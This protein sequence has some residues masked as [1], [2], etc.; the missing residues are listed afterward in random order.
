MGDEFY[1]GFIETDEKKAIEKFK[2]RNDF[3]TYEQCKSLNG[4]AGVLDEDTC[5]GDFDN[6]EEAEI[7]LQMI[8][9]EQL[10]CRVVKT[11]R[12][13]HVLF[14]NKERRVDSCSTK[15]PTASTLTVDYKVGHKAS[16]EALKVNGVEREVVYDAGEYEEVPIHF[17]PVKRKVGFAN[18]GDSDGRN[19][20]LFEYILTLQDA[21]FVKDEIREIERV[22]NKYVL[23]DPLSEKELEIILR[24]ESFLK[25]SFSKSGK[26]QH[27]LL[28]DYLI[29]EKHIISVNEQLH[30]Y[31]NG[32][33]TNRI[34]L[35]NRAMIE[36]LPNISNNQRRETLTYMAA[37][38][39][40][41]ELSAINKIPVLNGLFNIENNALEEFTPNYIAKNKIPVAYNPAAYDE[42]IDKFLNDISCNDSNIRAIIEEMIGCCLYRSNS[43][44]TMFILTG[45]GSNGKS[46]LLR[47]LLNLLGNENT[48]SVD[49]KELDRTFKTAELFGKLANIGDDISN[50][51][52]RNSS[53]IKKLSSG[54]RNNAEKKG[55]DPFEFNNYATMIFSCNTM[56]K[57]NDNTNGL[58]R[59]LLFIPLN[60]VFKKSVDFENNILQADRL[61]YLLKLGIEGLQ[62]YLRSGEF[63]AS[64]MAESTKEDYIIANDPVK[65]FL[66]DFEH[67]TFLNEC[68]KE[69]FMRFRSWCSNNGHTYDYDVRKF[70][71]EVN[72]ITGFKS[73]RIRPPKGSIWHGKE[74]KINI[75]VLNNNENAEQTGRTGRRK[76]T[77]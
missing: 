1:K 73:E 70:T 20:A 24:D 15:V 16:Y 30:I 58:A 66:H 71:K 22:V 45:E 42:E 52:I 27:N 26:F 29:R 4:F 64:N 38:A 75:F 14:K 36:Q 21:G 8:K 12:G 44:Q 57:V 39:K 65:G 74:E 48:C 3:K 72:A 2:N 32:I 5:L 68:T 9:G 54:E 63:T 28:G 6:P 77:G 31:E 7:A 41:T 59:R 76:R 25:C 19:S 23:K 37:V 34:K 67:K 55:Q 18:M 53:L 40:D 10:K 50:E 56:P 46:T 61:E 69:V 43:F 60:N 35:L 17:L 51:T 11:D 49:L 13:I 33:Y 47:L 62:R